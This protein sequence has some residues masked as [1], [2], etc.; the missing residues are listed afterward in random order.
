MGRPTK[1]DGLLGDLCGFCGCVDRHGQPKHVLQLI[2]AKGLVTA[3]QFAEWVI[4]SDWPD[5]DYDDAEY[6]GFRKRWVSEIA[7]R[8]AKH[9]GA[10]SVDAELLRS[11]R[12]RF[13]RAR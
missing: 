8:F 13:P 2:P 12:W 1:F 9:M 3:Q 5:D 11:G 4:Q 6:A 10:E 7:R